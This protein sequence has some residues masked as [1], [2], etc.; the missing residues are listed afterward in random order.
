ME[1][2]KY[3][4]NPYTFVSVN[5]NI[6]RKEYALIEND[7]ISGYFEY[8]IELKSPLIIPNTSNN[9]FR[10][11]EKYSNSYGIN[12]YENLNNKN[13][14]NNS[15]VPIISGSEIRGCIRS[16]YEALT[17]SCYNLN[18]ENDIFLD[19][20]A[21]S[22]D[23]LNPCVFIYNGKD[24][25]DVYSASNYTYENSNQIQNNIVENNEECYININNKKYFIF[26]EIGINLVDDCKFN[27]INPNSK[28]KGLLVIEN[29]KKRKNI[30]VYVRKYKIKS[31]TKDS[32]NY[33]KIIAGIK[34]FVD[35]NGNFIYK[36]YIDAFYKNKSIVMYYSSNDFYFPPSA[37]G[38]KC[39]A[40]SLILKLDNESM[41]SFCNGLGLC[42]AC[43]LFGRINNENSVSS[44]VRFSDARI[45]FFDYSKVKSI[46]LISSEPKPSNVYFYATSN[47]WDDPD[48]QV[49]G[50]KFY[51]H[52]Q[53][54]FNYLN[55]ISSKT[56]SDG[57][58]N[59]KIMSKY[60]Y[61]DTDAI[62]SNGNQFNFK[63][64]VYFNDISLEEMV[65]LYKAISLVDKKH[66]HKLGHGKPFG[67]GSCS[68]NI[69]KIYPEGLFDS[70]KIKWDLD[71]QNEREL[72]YILDLNA[73]SFENAPV[74]YPFSNESD[75]GYEWFIANKK[76]EVPLRLPELFEGKNRKSQ[77]IKVLK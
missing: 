77:K 66:A 18:V 72:E 46:V 2:D 22:K 61:F 38:K 60:D 25:W 52:H 34:S 9:Q 42:P 35:S 4:I 50:R 5:N 74:V 75:N 7:S 67:F 65:N 58:D 64:K 24:G 73:L 1:S 3:F 39:F 63:G 23:L 29:R 28:I 45:E 49:R 8:E 53:P 43:H 21:L 40:S 36:N 16:I 51:W 30:A 31:I 54:D 55:N 10:N 41:N 26:D 11:E 44:K 32:S 27:S 37:V 69:T 59:K 48:C 76:I 47:D 12:S 15:Y 56:R 6:K 17:N 71:N 13:K 62:T 14:Q 68:F 57:T 33:K 70:K 20:K 19:Q